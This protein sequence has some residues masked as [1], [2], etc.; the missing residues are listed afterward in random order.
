MSRMIRS[1][2]FARFVRTYGI[3]SLAVEVDVRP[4]AIYHWIRGATTP[5]AAG[6]PLD[7]M[8]TASLLF[9]RAANGFALSNG[10]GACKPC[11]SWKTATED[12]YFSRGKR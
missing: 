8:P 3:E 11:H 6:C 4:S 9:A 7:R 2:W 1:R 5:L 10:Q 12:S